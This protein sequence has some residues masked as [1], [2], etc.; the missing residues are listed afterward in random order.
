LVL[1]GVSVALTGD[2][3]LTPRVPAAFGHDFPQQSLLQPHHRPWFG[4]LFVLRHVVHE[5]RDVV[6]RELVASPASLVVVAELRDSS[7]HA[8]E[9]PPPRVLLQRVH[10]PQH[11]V[12]LDY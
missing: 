4:E 5:V 7:V 1:T 11:V 8:L 2:S 6:K 10:R 3:A 12:Q 9:N